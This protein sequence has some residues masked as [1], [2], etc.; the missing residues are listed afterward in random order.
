M[1]AV[2]TGLS[3]SSS[4]FALFPDELR[5]V[6]TALV[7]DTGH[8][9]FSVVLNQQARGAAG[10]RCTLQ[11]IVVSCLRIVNFREGFLPE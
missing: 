6:H 1:R 8:P 11:C 5:L 10:T 9:L 3:E 4:P 2:L 7:E